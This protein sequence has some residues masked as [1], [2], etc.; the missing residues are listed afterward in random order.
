MFRYTLNTRVKSKLL[1]AL[2]NYVCSVIVNFFL[3]YYR[4]LSSR[5]VRTPRSV[6]GAPALSTLERQTDLGSTEAAV[7]PG[8]LRD[9]AI[10]IN[11][12]NFCLK[13]RRQTACSAGP[14]V[15][16]DCLMDHFQKQIP[17]SAPR[18]KFPPKSQQSLIF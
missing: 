8:P 13:L 9:T 14:A 17:S 3:F 7:Q 6:G 18:L 1:H 15:F 16:S 12:E 5:L 2:V 11:S 4:N 10:K